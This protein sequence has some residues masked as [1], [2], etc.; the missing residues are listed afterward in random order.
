MYFFYPDLRWSFLGPFLSTVLS[1][2]K[3]LRNVLKLKFL[4]FRSW[5]CDS[6]FSNETKEALPFQLFFIIT[7]LYCYCLFLR[8]TQNNL[9]FLKEMEGTLFPKLINK[10]T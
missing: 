10:F 6:C 9:E 7:Y 3:T 4:I 2:D 1:E 8:L 5:S